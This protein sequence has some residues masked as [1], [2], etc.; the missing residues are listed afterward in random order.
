MERYRILAVDDDVDTLDLI[1]MTLKED[2][3]V[4][5]LSNPM[6]IYEYLEIFEPDLLLLDIMM[7][8]I[9]GFQI[10]E[11]LSK[12][13]NF[14]HIPIIV[15]SA[16][17]SVREMKY[18]YKLGVRLYLTKPFQTERLYKNVKMSFLENPA[19]RKKSHTLAQALTKIQ[20]KESYKVSSGG[21]QGQTQEQIRIN[22]D[23]NTTVKMPKIP[24]IN[25]MPNSLRT[26]QNTKPAAQPQTTAPQTTA[27]NPASAPKPY[28][29]KPASPLQQ[30]SATPADKDKPANEDEQE[31]KKATWVN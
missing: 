6:D 2:F 29:A 7:P 13:P 16:K 10:I 15:L 30:K 1:H 31:E 23:G 4:L 9:T 5:T 8:K 20:L 28:Q 21:K 3:D 22:I 19:I 26:G 18:G 14:R 12:N 24:K 17:D 11:I 27:A 25:F